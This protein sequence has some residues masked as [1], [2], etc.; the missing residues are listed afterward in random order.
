MGKPT[1]GCWHRQNQP[2]QSSGTSSLRNRAR[3]PPLCC[4]GHP[5]ILSGPHLPHLSTPC[6]RKQTGLHS[7]LGGPIFRRGLGNDSGPISQAMP[8]LSARLPFL[9]RP[10]PG[11]TSPFAQLLG[12]CQFNPFLLSRSLAAGLGVE[13]LRKG[14]RS[15][16]DSGAVERPEGL[17]L[18][19]APE[20]CHPLRGLLCIPVP[21]CKPDIASSLRVVMG[22]ICHVIRS[23]LMFVF[24]SIFLIFGLYQL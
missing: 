18:A 2:S 13:I 14:T 6:I 24:L 15:P 17:N 21:A 20:L 8:G 11:C 9:T 23:Q 4:L 3:H 7:E 10:S 12:W 22:T 19:S 1:G 16:V 5:G